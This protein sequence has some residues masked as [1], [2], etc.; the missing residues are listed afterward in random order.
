MNKTLD[1][2]QYAKLVIYKNVVL[3]FKI[4]SQIWLK[5]MDGFIDLSFI[6]F[7]IEYRMKEKIKVIFPEINVKMLRYPC[8][9]TIGMDVY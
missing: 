9:N 8:N 5:R 2:A 3:F 1:E 4:E 7:C 6:K